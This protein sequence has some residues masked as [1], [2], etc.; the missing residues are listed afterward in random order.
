M[1]DDELKQ[2]RRFLDQEADSLDTDTR[3]ALNRARRE[4]L[5]ASPRR[6]PLWWLG[7]GLATAAALAAVLLLPGGDP[8]SVAPPAT[9]DWILLAGAETGDL[10]M[11]REDMAFLLWLEETHD[12]G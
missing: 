10:E 9:E 2:A 8:E 5:S 3:R 11:A 6:V 4:A 7:S 12:A 1:R